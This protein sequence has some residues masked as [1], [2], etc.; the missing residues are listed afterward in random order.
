MGLAGLIRGAGVTGTG[1]PFTHTHQ[2]KFNMSGYA[3][4]GLDVVGVG[5]IG[6]G[7][8]GSGTVKRFGCIEGVEI[9]ALCDLEPDRVSRAMDSVRPLGHRPDGY[10]GGE[11]EWR[12]VCERKDIDLIAVVTPWHLHTPMCVYSM[13]HGKHAYTE[14]PAAT[15]IEDCWELVETSERTRMHCVQDSSSCHGY[16]GIEWSMPAIVLNMVR[17]GFFGEI[18]HAEGA[19]IHDILRNIFSYKYH[20]MWRLR[21]NMNVHGNLYPQHGLVPIL[22]MMD[23]NCGDRMEYLV[24]V[25]SGDFMTGN[26]EI[27]SELSAEPEVWD[28]F[29]G[30][31]YRG[32]MNTTV[33]RTHRG[34]TIM[35]QHD[36]SSPRPNVRFRLI[37]GTRATYEQ[38]ALPPGKLATGHE[39]W[40]PED[41]FNTLA[42]RNLPE[43]VKRFNAFRS[44]SRKI[45]MSEGSYY[46]TNP[47]E[48]RL[49][50]CLRNGLPMDMD[51]YEAAASSA[52][53]PLSIWSVANGSKPADVPDFTSGAW[54]TNM[55]GMD[56]S[57]ERGGG[58][59]KLL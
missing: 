25:S 9:R 22:Q 2:Q 52:I 26:P 59:T 19:Y 29:K 57:L 43:M 33:I 35:M 55:R 18:I 37:S 41:E 10:S 3:A 5:I 42:E 7:N 15:S 46:R 32:N 44:L 49:I 8:R 17:Q 56:I 48:W 58:T 31:Q 12:R 13:E 16:G 1:N 23:I 36:T 39:G 28:I 54:K 21:E 51:V 27:A 4:P 47:I 30:N 14:L 45:D 11:K 40:L 50:D 34:R 6:L 24:S 53:I 20:D 38:G